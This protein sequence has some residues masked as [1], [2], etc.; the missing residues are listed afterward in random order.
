MPTFVVF[1]WP[2]AATF[3]KTVMAFVQLQGNCSSAD[4]AVVVFYSIVYFQKA[5]G[6]AKCLHQENFLEGGFMDH[7]HYKTNRCT[8]T[9]GK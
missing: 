1:H 7:A 4:G 9:T 5:E 6:N 2:N 8:F 3:V